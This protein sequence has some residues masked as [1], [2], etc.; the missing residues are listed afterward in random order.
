MGDHNVTDILDTVPIQQAI[1]KAN[2][3]LTIFLFESRNHQPIDPASQ[4]VGN[5]THRKTQTIEPVPVKHHI[6]FGV[7]VFQ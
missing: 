5:V 4:R 7:A 6:Q 3:D 1:A 2:I